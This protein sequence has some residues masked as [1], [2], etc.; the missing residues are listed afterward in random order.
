MKNVILTIFFSLCV[1][2][3]A[4]AQSVPAS[5]FGTYE[6]S[7]SEMNV[8]DTRSIV[9]WSKMEFGEAEGGP[10]VTFTEGENSDTI[11][12]YVL[13]P[14]AAG[15]TLSLYFSHC[16]PVEYGSSDGCSAPYKEGQLL[17]QLIRAKTGAKTSY[18]T[19]WK[20]MKKETPKSYFKKT[21]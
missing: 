7:V 2:I 14:K 17:L 15:N 21:I 10:Y 3:T 19:V 18:T 13:V 16:M 8:T 6:G 1:A 11:L 5:W 4:N 20:D 9:T 12:T